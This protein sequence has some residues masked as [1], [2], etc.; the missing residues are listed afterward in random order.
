M[1]LPE[2]NL[3]M[4]LHFDLQ[5][6]SN[7]FTIVSEKLWEAIVD[8]KPVERRDLFQLLLTIE[9]LKDQANGLARASEVIS[10]KEEA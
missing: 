9:K 10:D 3:L 8:K 2:I 6:T 7:E 1:K 5:T 4:R